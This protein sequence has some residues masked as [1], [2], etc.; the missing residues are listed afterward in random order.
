MIKK[1]RFLQLRG[2]FEGYFQKQ[3]CKLKICAG[4]ERNMKFLKC[5]KIN[6]NK[7]ILIVLFHIVLNPK[8]WN[9]IEI[10]QT[11]CINKSRR[12]SERIAKYSYYRYCLCEKLFLRPSLQYH[13][14]I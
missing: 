1:T 14:K 6:N 9:N 13:R 11:V 12:G 5:G 8:P 10:T 7:L 4:F 3:F 2:T